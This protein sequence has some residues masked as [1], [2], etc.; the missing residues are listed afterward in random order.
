M[1]KGN[2]REKYMREAMKLALKA[3]GLTSPN[4]LV[5]ALVVKNGNVIGRGFHAKA[6]FPHAEA[7][8]L[9]QAGK[10]A[11][12]AALYVTLEPCTHFGRTPPCTARILE[13]G[14]KE[15]YVGAVD[16]N[17]LNN[18]KGIAL[19]RGKKLKVEVG[20]LQEPLK[21]MNE[22]FTKY[23]TSRMPLVTVKTAQS[24]DGKIATRTRN[25]KWITSDKSRIY[26][27]RLRRYYDAVMVGAN[28]VLIDNPKLDAWFS[29]H[30]PAKV[31]VDSQ[32]STHPGAAIFS[33]GGRVI[34][35]TLASRSGQEIENR[36]MLSKKAAILEVREK[37]GQVDLKDAMRRLA[38]LGIINIL[39]EG[40]GTL[41]GSLFD[42][43][44]VDKILFFV[45]FKIIG[46]KDAIS[47]V[48]GRGVAM[49]DKAVA[50]KEVSLRRIGEDL[51]VEAYVHGDH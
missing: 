39:V 43:G 51:L 14:I 34:I 11:R 13:S 16:P 2:L 46:G 24:L 38:R 40:G 47:S 23:I 42:E 5:G 50:L 35:V 15:V 49:V 41:N 4:P 32:L 44:L 33:G 31:V 21:K 9:A 22:A 8:A 28:T 12:G 25:S 17:P 20:F 26:S 45:S 6:G 30:Q 3:K 37:S 36:R 27:H 10:N 48:M 1:K 29:S 19:L 7:L 18:G